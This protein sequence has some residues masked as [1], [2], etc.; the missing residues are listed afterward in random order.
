[1]GHNSTKS[2]QVIVKNEELM[3][4]EI[5]FRRPWLCENAFERFNG[6]QLP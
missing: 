6:R 2:I 1:M 4:T 3:Q 5:T